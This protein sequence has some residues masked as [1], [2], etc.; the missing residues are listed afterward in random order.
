MNGV[1][2]AA[3]GRGAHVRGVAEHR[4]QRHRNADRLDFADHP[5]HL[6]RPRREF[7]K[8]FPKLSHTRTTLRIAVD[9]EHGVLVRVE[10]D[11]STMRREIVA[12][13]FEV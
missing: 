12:K 9:S 1:V 8:R 7:G 5:M 4:Q 3:L 10:G 13:R 6:M 2:G 11:W